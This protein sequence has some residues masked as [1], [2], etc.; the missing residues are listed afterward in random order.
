MTPTVRPVLKVVEEHETSSHSPMK[1]KFC[2][3][4]MESISYA[5]GGI[6]SKFTSYFKFKRGGIMNSLE[7][8]VR[9]RF[10]GLSYGQP[11]ARADSAKSQK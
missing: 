9:V 6:V 8:T 7:R 11:L 5:G 1:D 2:E 3:M 4:S 10:D